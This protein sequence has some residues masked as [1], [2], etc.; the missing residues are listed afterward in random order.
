MAKKVMRSRQ[1]KGH[2]ALAKIPTG[3]AGFDE[4]VFGGLPKGR[5]TLVAGDAGC[6]K[7]FFAMEFLV[8]GAQQFDEP[9]LMVSFEETS[10]EL[11]KNFSL[12]GIAISS[13]IAKKKLSFEY[14]S[15]DRNEIEET[16]LYDLEGLFVRLDYA[17]KSIGAKRI[18]LDTIEALFGGLQ[19]KMIVR[20]ELRRLFR[21]LKDRGITAIITG[22][23]GIDTITRH[24]L[25]EFVSDCVILLTHKVV[26]M[27]ATRRLRIIKYRGSEHGTDETPFLISGDGISVFSVNA[28]VLEHKVS[29]DRISS[30]VPDLDVMI[31]GKGYFRGSSILVTGTAGTGKTTMAAQFADAACRRKEKVAYFSF[32]ES[33]DQIARNME[34][35][36]ID[37]ARHLKSGLL[38]IHASRPTAFGLEMHLAVMHQIINDISPSVVIVDPISNLVS[39]G[40]ID[41]VRS[42]VIR[43]L[44]F[45]KVKQITAMFTDLSDVGFSETTG[46]GVSSLMD[47]WILLRTF[48]V[49]GERNRGIHV[50]KT[51]GIKGSNQV[52]EFILTSHGIKLVD[53]YIGPEG[54]F[55]GTARIA[56]TAKEM[57]AALQRDRDLER[58]NREFKR[59][60]VMFEAEMALLRSKYEA[61]E[62]DLRSELISDGSREDAKVQARAELAVARGAN[63][64]TTGRDRR[65]K[66][67]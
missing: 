37:L 2:S 54:M 9:G 12:S 38:K 45:I 46:I 52:R 29:R 61:E 15:I 43:L 25:E 28:L 53:A 64:K 7:T 41:E 26:N 65:N 1:F 33:E 31:G 57:A 63:R 40:N 11:L 5:P 14:I 67:R 24:G 10:E 19:N 44:D 56:Q 59:K 23:Q 58:K 39:A 51:R 42:M 50:L 60:R 3:I 48:E 32:E 8:R 17:I 4:I 36:G 62:E 6:G 30:G 27:V 20:G 49:N 22:E 21:W 47:A 18:V 66:D 13:L 34:S 35:V 55:T 16:G